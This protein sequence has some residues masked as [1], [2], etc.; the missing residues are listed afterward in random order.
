MALWK[1]SKENAQ[2]LLARTGFVMS[3]LSLIVFWLSDIVRPGFVSRYFS[4]HVFAVLAVLF[5]VWWLRTRTRKS[6]KRPWM[7]AVVLTFFSLLFLLIC[8]VCGEGFGAF[9]ILFSI[10]AFFTPWLIVKLID[11]KN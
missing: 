10:L 11:S 7:R 8:W 6:K 2:A 3:V 1:T 9:R 5:A 4:P